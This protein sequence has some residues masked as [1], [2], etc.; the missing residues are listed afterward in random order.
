M[1][2]DELAG[3]DGRPVTARRL[4]WD[5]HLTA[6]QEFDL[7]PYDHPDRDLS[8]PLAVVRAPNLPGLVVYLVGGQEADP[9][10]IRP[11][12]EVGHQEG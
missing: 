8:G 5:E 3:L 6:E 9:K 12:A 11:A 2:P 7:D 4:G 1:T 10:T